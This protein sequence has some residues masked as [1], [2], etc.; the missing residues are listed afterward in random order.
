MGVVMNMK[1]HYDKFYK[2]FCYIFITMFLLFIGSHA[3]F[4]AYPKVYKN[5][6]YVTGSTLDQQKLDIYTPRESLTSSSIHP[7]LIYVHG[8]AWNT[9]DKKSVTARK[10]RA[11]TDLGI[12]VVSVNYRLSP[13]YTHPAHVKDLAMA[14]HWIS[15]HIGEYGGNT[16]NMA[17]SGHSAG[18]HLVALLG[19]H[20]TYL[21]EQGG[22]LNMFRS[23]IPVDTATFDLTR[24]Q[25][26]KFARFIQR[27]RNNAFGTE[28][29]GLLDSSPLYHAEKNVTPKLSPFLIFVTAERKDAVTQTLRF[30]LSL[31]KN[32]HVTRMVIVDEGLTHKDMNSA[33]FKSGSTIFRNIIGVFKNNNT[34][35]KKKKI[36]SN[37]F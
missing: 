5:I 26:G 7:V 29:E 18:A 22:S 16:K 11:Y 2:T 27:M 10:A 35:T 20:P 30:N 8:G 3:C 32:G 36:K 19:T 12:I 6:P 23:V 4:A 34:L 9:G 14:M 33:I 24:K 25:E 21:K 1:M 15:N 37:W 28:E 17:L 31:K 13:D